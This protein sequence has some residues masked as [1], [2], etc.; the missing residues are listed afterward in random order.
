MINTNLISQ[1]IQ[2]RFQNCKV[3]IVERVLN[4]IEAANIDTFGRKTVFSVI[5]LTAACF[6]L[7]SFL[8]VFFNNGNLKN[9]SVSKSFQQI[10]VE[11]E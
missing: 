8:S 5:V 2:Q 1:I 3:L 4:G 10:E 7:I 11:K 9:V 6:Y